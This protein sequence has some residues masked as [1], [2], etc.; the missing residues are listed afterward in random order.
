M[1]TFSDLPNELVIEVWG[2]VIEPEDV[3]SLALVSKRI[4]SLAA[5]FV[6]EHTR[7]KQ[8]YSKI[9]GPKYQTRN[10]AADLLKK[11]LLNP[12]IALYVNQ[13][14][15]HGCTD[16]WFSNWLM[17][18]SQDT[19]DLFKNAIQYSS[20]I[21]PSEVEDWIADIEKGDKDPIITLMV[22][23]RTKLKKIE[24][25]GCYQCTDGT[26]R[27]LLKTLRSITESSEVPIH[28]RTS[29]IESDTNDRFRFSR[30]LNL[31]SVS[32]LVIDQVNIDLD[33]VSRL[34]RTMNEL[35]SFSYIPNFDS[36]FGAFQ[37]CE[38]LLTCSQHSLRKLHLHSLGRNESYTVEIAHFEVPAA[39]EIDFV[40]LLGNVNG[41]CR[42]LANMLPMSIE[43]VEIRRMW[44][45]TFE[46]L[47]QVILQMVEIK[48]KR[49][50]NLKS[51]T[52]GVRC[53]ESGDMEPIAE[54]AR[55]CADVG[56]L[57]SIYMF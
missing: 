54:L 48:T 13:L 30:P 38:K 53:H 43:R 39:L 11:M 51:L 35:K 55:S 25:G 7:L 4:Y 17:S 5:P 27:Y 1:A 32:D 9:R 29:T 42:K 31:S 28:Y 37:I 16:G 18:Y 14:Q 21:A 23:R 26:D 8:Q 44:N 15:I 24:L 49:L 22:M 36:P 12:R 34:L 40:V 41:V 2:Y 6:E 56:V 20:S 52:F 33:E 57:L 19:I 10:E 46:T 45:I 47:A 3:E 50:P